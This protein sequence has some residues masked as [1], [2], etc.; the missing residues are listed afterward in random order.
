MLNFV[1]KPHKPNRATGP[2]SLLS[3]KRYITQNEALKHL[4]E[5]N[6]FSFLIYMW[7]YAY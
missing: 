2:Y 6:T 4:I 3:H 1:T 5:Q 7:L